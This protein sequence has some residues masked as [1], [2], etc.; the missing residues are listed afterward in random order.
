MLCV[1]VISCVFLVVCVWDDMCLQ[2]FVLTIPHTWT[3][4]LPM[5][6]Y[7]AVLLLGLEILIRILLFR[8]NKY[9]GCRLFFNAC[10]QEIL[11]TLVWRHLA[12][13]VVLL[14]FIFSLFMCSRLNSNEKI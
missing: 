9:A 4:V 8:Y 1:A 10:Y 12:I 3:S 11:I 5:H 14:Y 7:T 13:A 2:G 6:H